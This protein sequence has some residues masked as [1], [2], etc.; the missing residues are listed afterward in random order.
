MKAT[1]TAAT[2]GTMTLQATTEAEAAVVEAKSAEAVVAEADVSAG[3][4][5]GA[6]VAVTEVANQ[7]TSSSGATNAG[8]GAAEVVVNTEAGMVHAA[9]EHCWKREPGEPPNPKP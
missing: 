5:A 4:G 3:A 9:G 6:R 2:E 8:G 7:G 1:K